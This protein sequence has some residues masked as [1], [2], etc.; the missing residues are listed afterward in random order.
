MGGDGREESDGERG[1]SFRWWRLTREGSLW[2]KRTRKRSGQLEAD[3]RRSEGEKPE[4]VGGGGP[5]KP[6]SF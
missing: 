3:V 1:G 5:H 6:Y 2:K 4:Q